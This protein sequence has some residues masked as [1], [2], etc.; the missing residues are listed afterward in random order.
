MTFTIRPFLQVKCFFVAMKSRKTNNYLKID[1]RNEAPYQLTPRLLS[2]KLSSR[3][4]LLSM[5][6]IGKIIMRLGWKYG[7]ETLKLSKRRNCVKKCTESKD[8]CGNN[9]LPDSKNYLLSK[10]CQRISMGFDYQSITHSDCHNCDG[11]SVFCD[12]LC[13]RI[14]PDLEESSSRRRKLLG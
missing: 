6:E 1:C 14:R 12:N 7:L 4:S 10:G 5:R 9:L 13:D 2:L 8:G 11:I 3:K